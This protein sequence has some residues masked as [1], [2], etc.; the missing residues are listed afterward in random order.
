MINNDFLFHYADKR[1]LLNK[2]RNFELNK[3][4]DYHASHKLNY[5][6]ILLSQQ[7]S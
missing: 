3:Y 1:D 4:A 6:I 2:K 5:F 7:F